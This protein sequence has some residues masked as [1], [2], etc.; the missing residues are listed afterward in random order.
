M[1]LNKIL[2]K[3]FDPN[4]S[5]HVTLGP[6]LGCGLAVIIAIYS[7][8]QGYLLIV[9]GRILNVFLDSGSGVYDTMNDI[10][11]GFAIIIIGCISM[12]LFFVVLYEICA[13]FWNLE[14]ATCEYNPDKE[15]T[16]KQD[17]EDTKDELK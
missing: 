6:V 1:S 10:L 4:K 8:Y 16:N 5:G 15:N 3:Y 11:G 7:I 9:T 12:I 14:I 2:C 17:T 13:Q